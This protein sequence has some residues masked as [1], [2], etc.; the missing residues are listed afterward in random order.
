M[1]AHSI[2][3]SAAKDTVGKLVAYIL[4]AK[5]T[6]DLQRS[7]AATAAYVV[8]AQNGGHRV[9]APRITNCE[10]VDVLWAIKEIEQ[11][12]ARNTRSRS[13][14]SYHLVISFP[15]GERPDLAQL[16]DIEDRLCEAIGYGEHQRIS[17]IH[18]DTSC[19]HV[20][21]AINKVHPRSLRNVELR[22]DYARLMD[23]C[24][25]LEKKHGLQRT[26]HG[27]TAEMKQSQRGQKMETFAGRETLLRWIRE[28]ARD[29]LIKVVAAA[30][31]WSEVHAELARHGL[32]MRLR[33]AGLVIG[34]K[35][36]RYSVKASDVDVSLSFKAMTDRLGPFE[37]PGPE[38]AGVKAEQSYTGRPKHD[39]ALSAA[40]YARFQAE[41]SVAEAARVEARK[42]IAGRH[43]DYVKDLRDYH[44]Q[45]RT[46][47]KLD[48]GLRGPAKRAAYAAL[49]RERSA[50]WLNQKALASEQRKAVTAAY[51][52]P[53]W[54]QFLEKEASRGD[55]AALAALRSRAVRREAFAR[56]ILT[57]AD[58][59][60]A[61]HVVYQQLDPKVRPNGDVVYRVKDGGRVTCSSAEV[62]CDELTT[63]AAFLALSLASDRFPGQP[64]EI[65]G[66]AAFKSAVVQVAAIS[67]F[68]VTF[69][70]PDLEAARL[71][72]AGPKSKASEKE[73]ASRK[74]QAAE[75]Y[76]ASRN[77]LRSRVSD[78]P[79]HRLW[80]SSDQG[81]FS[82]AGRR[83]FKDGTEAVLLSRDGLTF[84][85]PVSD[86]QAAKA[87]TWRVGQS[88]SVDSQGRFRADEGRGR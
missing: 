52:L 60:A 27:A 56:D 19:L 61:R 13:D 43:A 88:V 21:V 68:E 48:R 4:D 85:K 11:V 79:E 83:L 73:G 59:S 80:S 64:L 40:L 67:G 22:R 34:L 58:V 50:D 53:T 3:R 75:D 63:G 51:P 69:S 41:R 42:D 66:S 23:A 57:A 25:E 76:V 39:P 74:H 55:E 10:A 72:A 70:D 62:R 30:K 37:K 5:T 71:A 65:A 12:Q 29:D 31:D 17:A 78:V 6:S 15:E 49:K 28:N 14:K 45:R 1:I 87:S 8:D 86:A 82:Y 54:Q 20:H 35:G 38:V 84:V 16:R 2:R 9:V 24:V 32:E 44:V 36:E 18:D 47:V 33:G 7:F 81:E 46:S 26:N 77:A